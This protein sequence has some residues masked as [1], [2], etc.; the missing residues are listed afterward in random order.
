[1]SQ[2]QTLSQRWA[3]YRPSKGVW[4]WSFIGAIVLTMIVGFTAGG[5]VTGGTAQEMAE[6]AASSTRSGLVAKLC[7]NKFISTDN[8]EGRLAKLKEADSWERDDLIEDGGWTT[9]A[10]LTEGGSDAADLCAE[11]LAAMD[12]LPATAAAPATTTTED[13]TVDG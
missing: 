5:W 7:V 6:N 9:I 2:N 1:M 8:A 10:G 3:E 12:K 4:I 13:S 11:Q